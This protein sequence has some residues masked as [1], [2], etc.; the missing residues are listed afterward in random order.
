ME[1]IE[2]HNLIGSYKDKN[3]VKTNSWFFKTGLG[4]YG[5]GDKFLGIIVPVARKIAIILKDISI[6]EVDMLLES[7][8]HEERLIGLLILVSRYERASKNNDLELCNSVFNYYLTKTG[9]INNWDLVD[10]SCY[11]IVGKHLINSDRS[12][13]YKL[14][15]S[16]NLWE[17]RISVI[18]TLAFI[19]NEEY[20][21]TFNITDILLSD[22]HDLIQ[23]ACG[24]MLREVGKRVSMDKLKEFLKT[25]YM[26]MPRTMLRY[27]IEKFPEKER[28]RYIEG[29][30]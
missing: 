14:A 26:E 2:I 21:D 20:I 7:K 16:E 29:K 4:E 27:S 25:R 28:R 30:V 12:I 10:V 15:K 13:L 24:W 1:Y 22:S 9:R 18:S 3:K 17:R 8:Y 6:D 23:K 19:M 11:K 5:E